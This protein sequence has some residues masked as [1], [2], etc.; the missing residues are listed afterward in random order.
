MTGNIWTAYIRINRSS[1]KPVTHWVLERQ[2][3][4]LFNTHTGKYILFIIH[5][6]QLNL[7]CTLT[8]FTITTHQ[9]TG[10]IRIA[11]QCPFEK[12]KILQS[13]HYSKP[14]IHFLFFKESPETGK[15]SAGICKKFVFRASSPRQKIE[16]L[17][18]LT[19]V[20][21]QP[22]CNPGTQQYINISPMLACAVTPQD[23]LVNVL[24]CSKQQPL[25]PFYTA[26]SLLSPDTADSIA[27]GVNLL[28]I[29]YII[30]QSYSVYQQPW[31]DEQDYICPAHCAPIF[32]NRIKTSVGYVQTPYISSLYLHS[33]SVV[34]LPLQAQDLIDLGS[35]GTINIKHG[36]R[37][38]SIS[39]MQY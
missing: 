38:Y 33:S 39:T 24:L 36:K 30:L 26:I 32:F 20:L 35:S 6:A 31:T 9:P 29:N 18:N 19:A 12:C 13:I 22:A 1:T 14:K 23:L 4:K 5:Y 7:I 17:P 28:Y 8:H 25:Q 11:L 16:D 2:D 34:L 15:K 37:I 3:Q 10:K 27:G 21:H